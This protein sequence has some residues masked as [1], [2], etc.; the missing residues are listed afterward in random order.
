EPLSLERMVEILSATNVSCDHQTVKLAMRSLFNKWQEDGRAIG[1]GLMLQKVSG[2]YLFT[3]AQKTAVVVKKILSRKMAELNKSQME[4][5]SIVAYRQP[6]TR[7]DIDEIRGVDSSSALKK[8]M[9]LKLLK[10]LGKSEGLGRPLLYGT[11]KHFLE[12][13]SLNSLNDLPTLKQFEALGPGDEKDV[14][15]LGSNNV[16]VKDLFQSQKKGSMFSS[17]VERLSDEALKSLDEALLRLE[18]VTKIE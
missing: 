6:I 7:V 10:I 14:S 3:T 18:G 13:F 16:S 5:L 1:R 9:Q 4:V 12:F 15:D 8:L 2:G 17:D 11:T